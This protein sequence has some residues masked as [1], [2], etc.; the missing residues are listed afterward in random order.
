MTTRWRIDLVPQYRALQM[1]RSTLRRIMLKPPHE[2]IPGLL[3]DLSKRLG[4]FPTD[5][6]EFTEEASDGNT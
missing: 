2:H 1:D 6:A 4:C 5:L 3:F